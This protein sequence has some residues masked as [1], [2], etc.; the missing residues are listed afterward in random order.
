MAGNIPI[1]CEQPQRIE[2]NNSPVTMGEEDVILAITRQE[3]ELKQARYRDASRQ[4]Q[5]I[6]SRLE[7]LA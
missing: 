5:D 2:G 6:K 1:K 4:V 7:K 3:L